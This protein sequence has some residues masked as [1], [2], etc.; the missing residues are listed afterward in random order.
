MFEWISVS[1]VS[2]AHLDAHVHYFAIY[3]FTVVSL[4]L[5]HLCGRRPGIRM[6][7]LTA[8]A[9]GGFTLAVESSRKSPDQHGWR[10]REKESVGNN[11]PG[12]RVF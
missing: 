5:I 8:M 7:I 4:I 2:A 1:Y 12:L 9:S 3:S 11:H 10:P 6:M